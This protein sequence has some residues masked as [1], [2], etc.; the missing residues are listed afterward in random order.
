MA[1]ISGCRDPPRARALSAALGAAAV[2]D[3]DS[4]GQAVVQ[5]G[6]RDLGAVFRAKLHGG[7]L[8]GDG[9]VWDVVEGKGVGLH[10]GEEE[11]ETIRSPP[12]MKVDVMGRNCENG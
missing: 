5:S 9:V 7:H 3:G 4:D 11:E 8:S 1:D 6:D 10:L 2:V 12:D